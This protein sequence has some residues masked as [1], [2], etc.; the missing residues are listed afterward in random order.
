MTPLTEYNEIIDYT[1]L[2][3]ARNAAEMPAK[4]FLPQPRFGEVS[5]R[6]V[7]PDKVL[8]RGLERPLASSASIHNVCS[9]YTSRYTATQQIQLRLRQYDKI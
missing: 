7:F 6:A 9:R 3:I 2:Q 1:S 8:R 4:Q 5:L